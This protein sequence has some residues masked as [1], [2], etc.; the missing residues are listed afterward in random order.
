MLRV[1]KFDMARAL[2]SGFQAM[3]IYDQ[4]VHTS[5]G[6]FRL[7]ANETAVFARELEHVFEEVYR[8]EFPDLV[9]R[10]VIPVKSGVSNAAETHTYTEIERFGKAEIIDNFAHEFPSTEVTGAQTSQVI[11]SLG[12]SYQYSIQ[13]MRA[14]SVTKIKMPVEK[15]ETAREVMENLLDDLCIKGDT[16]TGLKGLNSIASNFNAP[17]KETTGTWASQWAAA[18]TEEDYRNVQ[19]GILADLR[20]LFVSIPTTTLNKHYADTLVLDTAAHNFLAFTERGGAQGSSQSL[21]AYVM[22]NIPGLKSVIPWARLNTAGASNASRAFALKRD[23]KV[24]YQV[25]PQDFE[26]FPP[27]ARWLAFVVPCHMRWGGVVSP[28]PKAHAYMDGFGA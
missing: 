3:G 25:I 6:P 16:A 4:I 21:L 15:A 2:I 11:K 18:V 1:E 23:P 19:A 5:H 13:E 24:L 22:A 17:T 9:G 27:Q 14:A 12:D 7:D 10:S 26:Q 8:K 20:A 28:Y